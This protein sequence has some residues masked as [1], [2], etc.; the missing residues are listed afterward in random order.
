M[1]TKEQMQEMQAVISSST[2]EE[3]N[4]MK[5]SAIKSLETLN[6]LM[7]IQ[8]IKPYEE[9]AAFRRIE[10]LTRIEAFERRKGLLFR[11]IYRLRLTRKYLR[12]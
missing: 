11:F 3:R 1:V 7:R 8:K 10:T 2:P 5:L 9:D 6:R 4:Q 12:Y